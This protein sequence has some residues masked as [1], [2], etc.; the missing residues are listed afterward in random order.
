MRDA[1]LDRL[2]HSAEVDVDHLLP[3]VLF[4]PVE[5][6]SDG[7]DACVGDDD[8]QPAELLNTAVHRGFERVVFADIDLGG[9]DPSVQRLDQVGC[10][11]EVFGSRRWGRRVGEGL[12]DVDGDDVRAFLRQPHCVAASLPPRCA[13]DE[14]DLALYPAGH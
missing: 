6:S 1:G 3:D 11:R 14:R 9:D 5:P 7:P 2:P 12:A 8:V 10:F 4:H 13:G